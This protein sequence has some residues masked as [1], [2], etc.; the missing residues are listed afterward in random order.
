VKKISQRNLISSDCN[1]LSQA[2][3][4]KSADDANG[5][6]R[7]YVNLKMDTRFPDYRLP[8]EQNGNMQLAAISSRTPSLRKRVNVGKLIEQAGACL[9]Q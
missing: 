5:R 9:E 2:S 1:Y 4:R 8:T 3:Q 6:P 7:N